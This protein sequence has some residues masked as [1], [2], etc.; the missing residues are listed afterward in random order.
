[1][2]YPPE[3]LACSACQRSSWPNCAQLDG[4]Y[5]AALPPAVRKGFTFPWRW[6]TNQPP[7]RRLEG[8]AFQPAR[9]RK[10]GAVLAGKPEKL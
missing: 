3:S 10:H 2:L 9:R 8:S 7:P 4:R 1:M 6:S 5:P